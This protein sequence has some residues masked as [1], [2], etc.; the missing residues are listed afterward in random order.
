MDGK[1]NIVSF[2]NMKG[3]VCKTTLCKEMALYLSQIKKRDILVI[4]IDPQANCTQSFFERYNIIK[5][6]DLDVLENKVKLPSIQNIF[7]KSKDGLSGID[8]SKVICELD[9]KLHL[10]P[11]DLDTVFMERETASGTAE[12]KL[13]NFVDEFDLREKYDYIFIDCPP[14]YSFY[15]VSALLVS[16]YYLVPLVPDIYSLLGL[17]LL[18]RVVADLKYSYRANF[19][20]HKLD[21]LGVVFT[22]IPKGDKGSDGRLKSN[23]RSIRGNFK[24]TYFFENNFKRATKLEASR[25]ST[26]I[27]DRQD[28]ELLDSLENICEEFERRLGD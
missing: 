16:D 8:L 22:K 26:F 25:L 27:I 4:D 17:D 2:L 7:T 12:Q 9:D 3:G 15:T 6:S 20:S 14:T 18:E 1:R 10:I 28:M 13:F 21:N 23:M 11:G 24:D 19:K 5:S